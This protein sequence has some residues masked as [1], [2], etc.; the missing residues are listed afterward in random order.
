MHGRPHE[1][2]LIEL[3]K[4]RGVQSAGKMYKS[5]LVNE[6]LRSAQVEAAK[7][8][9][10]AV[11]AQRHLMAAAVVIDSSETKLP[12]GYGF[13][14]ASELGNSEGSCIANPCELLCLS[15]LCRGADGSTVNHGVGTCDTDDDDANSDDDGV[16]ACDTDDDDAD[17]DD[18]A[19]G[20]V[21]YGNH[22][23]DSEADDENEVWSELSS[24]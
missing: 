17:S 19:P 2:G 11:A 20:G 24:S 21:Y 1:C 8:Q 10:V 15:V 22:R 23:Y 3:G 14:A 6:I 16:G 5:D 7:R 9:E 12:P 4:S 13:A 18:D